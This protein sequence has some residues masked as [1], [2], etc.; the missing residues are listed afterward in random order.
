[1]ISN[2]NVRVWSDLEENKRFTGADGLMVG[3]SLLGNP[4]W[5]VL[6]VV[7]HMMACL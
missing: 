6:H 2:G 7:S 5:V 3:E 1:V 4:W